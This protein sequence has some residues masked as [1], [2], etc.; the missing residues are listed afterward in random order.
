MPSKKSS[1]E[2][3]KKSASKTTTRSKPA[4]RAHTA[5]SA[6]PSRQ[7]AQTKNAKG[8]TVKTAKASRPRGPS[9]GANIPSTIARSDRH[10]QSLWRK[11]LASAEKTYGDGAL[12]H[13]VAYS[14]L[15]HEYEKT[16]N[17]WVRKDE[18]GPSDAQAARGPATRPRSTDKPTRTGRGHVVR[19][20]G[21]PVDLHAKPPGR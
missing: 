14:A 13:R 18:A 19:K 20:S 10:A 6:A 15:K 1:T 12:A 2:T 17:R 11:A 16:G 7:R 9:A 21:S 3:E 4:A 5:Q 8:K